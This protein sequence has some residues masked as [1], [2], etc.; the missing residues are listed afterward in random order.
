LL[1]FTSRPL[2]IDTYIV[3]IY[4][5]DKAKNTAQGWLENINLSIFIIIRANSP[6]IIHKY[7]IIISIIVLIDEFTKIQ[8][9][10][11]VGFHILY[12]PVNKDHIL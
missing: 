2:T 3:C 4:E 9:R 7:I 12:S 6:H 11:N 8:I 1:I 5:R 10:C